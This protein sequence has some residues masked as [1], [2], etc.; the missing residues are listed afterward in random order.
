ML[1]IAF[2]AP[3]LPT[4]LTVENNDTIHI[5][6][7]PTTVGVFGAVFRPASFLLSDGKRKVKDYLNDAGGPIAVAD[8]GQIILVRANGEVI[9]KHH[10][11]MGAVVRP[12]DVIFVPVKAHGSRFWSHFRTFAQS[13]LGLGVS[14]ATISTI[15]K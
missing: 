3:S 4:G 8:K 7:R 15:V 2:D 5:P 14:A 10:G 11:A 1:P 6:A 12:G 13:I 9:S